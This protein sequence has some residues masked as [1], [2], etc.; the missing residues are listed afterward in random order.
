M[1]K[2]LAAFGAVLIAAGSLGAGLAGAADDSKVKQ[3]A[4]EVESGGKEVG[5]AVADTAK[6]VGK[7]VVGGAEVAGEKIKEGGEAAKPKAKSAW[8]SVKTFF[9]KPFSK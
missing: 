7:T 1:I 5:H 9:T 6:G 4:K 8:E 3:G 2:I